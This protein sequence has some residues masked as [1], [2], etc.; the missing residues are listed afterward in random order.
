MPNRHKR[1][2][3]G[4]REWH[5]LRYPV[6][7]ILTC[8]VIAAAAL[9]GTGPSFAAT[10]NFSGKALLNTVYDSNLFLLPGYLSPANNKPR[11][12][13]VTTASA[14]VGLSL[15]FGRQSLN[16][17]A[18]IQNNRYSNYQSLNYTGGSAYLN[19]LLGIGPNWTGKAGYSY[20]RRAVS[21]ADNI[22]EEKNLY[23]L[24]SLVANANY[25]K[26]QPGLESGFGFNKVNL[27]YTL[28]LYETAKTLSYIYH[29]DITWLTLTGLRFGLRD[30]YTRGEFP[31]RIQPTSATQPLS[32]RNNDIRLVVNRQSRLGTIWSASVGYSRQTYP[33]FG[34]SLPDFGTSNFSAFVGSFN[35]FFFRSRRLGGEISL[36]RSVYAVQTQNSNFVVADNV[37]LTPTYK[38]SAK[39]KLLL[40][41]GYARLAYQGRGSTRQ[42]RVVN[43]GLSANWQIS[44]HWLAD[45]GY[46]WQH[47]TSNISRF[48]YNDSQIEAGLSYSF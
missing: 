9:L 35:Y 12:S 48:E 16:A 45:V 42:D 47:R 28:P 34:Q 41:L 20:S 19:L 23:R 18:T 3:R 25:R 8:S 46:T 39:I 40:D 30:T 14:K 36:S 2:G 6:H 5:R 32:W 33:T 26:N 15:P 24:A 13:F 1:K 10:S 43:L 44:Q 31:N 37:E 29:A 27:S 21:F 7:P 38:L 4:L 17:G 22:S 11:S